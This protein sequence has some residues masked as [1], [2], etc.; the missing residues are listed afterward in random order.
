[1]LRYVH[2]LPRLLQ[3]LWLPAARYV[4][5]FPTPKHLVK[6]WKGKGM[7]KRRCRKIYTLNRIQELESVYFLDL[8][9]VFVYLLIY[10]TVFVWFLCLSFNF[11]ATPGL[12]PLPCGKNKKRKMN[13]FYLAAPNG[14]RFW[15]GHLVYVFGSLSHFL[16]S[17]N[18][19]TYS[20][21]ISGYA[22]CVLALIS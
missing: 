2:K 18:L 20:P 11:V 15:N 5:P 1:M 16:G 12:L 14:G 19:F 13:S 17:S 8:F 6:F 9:L 22:S 21:W 4:L 7:M 10:L 3:Q